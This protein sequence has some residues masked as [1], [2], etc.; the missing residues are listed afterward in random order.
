[1]FKQMLLWLGLILMFIGLIGFGL[2]I[3][4]PQS[5]STLQCLLGG[6]SFGAGFAITL[7]GLRE[8]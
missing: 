4:H 5:I 6:S 3:F 2:T 7:V 8:K 1:M